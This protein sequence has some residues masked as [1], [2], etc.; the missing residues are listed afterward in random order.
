MHTLLIIFSL[1]IS[2]MLLR[3]VSVCRTKRR[4][5]GK[6]DERMHGVS[7]LG[8]KRPVL[9]VTRRNWEDEGMV[10]IVAWPM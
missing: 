3:L 9:Q 7:G 4:Q 8:V 2:F 10:L 1:F 5:S 6:K